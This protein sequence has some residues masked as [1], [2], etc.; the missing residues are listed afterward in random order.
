MLH[1][2]ASGAHGEFESGPALLEVEVSPAVVQKPK[3]P[4]SETWQVQ[5]TARVRRDGAN[6]AE[7]RCTSR[8][9]ARKTRRGTREP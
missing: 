6:V 3:P 2:A 9:I 7:L 1:A 5:R 4:R 8:G